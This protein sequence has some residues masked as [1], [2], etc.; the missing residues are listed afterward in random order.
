[1]KLFLGKLSSFLTIGYAIPGLI[2]AVGITRFLVFADR[3]IFSDLD[4][5]ITGSLVGLVL[6]L[7]HI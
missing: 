6:S 4:F 7:I 5:V 2:L 1:M 3:N